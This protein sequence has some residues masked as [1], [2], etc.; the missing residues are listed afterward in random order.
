MVLGALLLVA[1][2][3]AATLIVRDWSI[4]SSLPPGCSEAD[5]NLPGCRLT[6]PP[7]SQYALAF[8]TVVITPLVA[9]FVAALT[10]RTTDRRQ[11]EQLAHE[12]DRLLARQE[13]ERERQ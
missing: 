5:K 11:A 8:A 2:T 10:A 1:I 4:G 6:S 13:E 3:A 12:R 9:I 7:L